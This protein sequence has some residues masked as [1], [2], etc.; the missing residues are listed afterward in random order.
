MGQR[1]F[2]PEPNPS[3]TAQ[4]CTCKYWTTVDI[5]R[6]CFFF[7][8]WCKW[9]HVKA[10]T[11]VEFNENYY[12]VKVLSP[13]LVMCLK[14]DLWWPI[15]PKIIRTLPPEYSHPSTMSWWHFQITLNRHSQC[16]NQR[17]GVFPTRHPSIRACYWLKTLCAAHSHLWET[18]GLDDV[19]C[20]FF[21]FFLQM[22]S[23]Q[24]A[25]RWQ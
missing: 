12:Q 17:E 11:K 18:L 10:N 22:I 25:V 4:G 15:H 3:V 21:F 23:L 13:G 5:T 6:D 19:L 1:M 24:Y 8:C 7:L 20:F 2:Y 9:L 16:W 14:K